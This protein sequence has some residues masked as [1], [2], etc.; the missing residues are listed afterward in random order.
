MQ[1]LHWFKDEL[2]T[3]RRLKFL[4]EH[5][6]TGHNCIGIWSILEF[7]LSAQLRPNYGM[8]NGKFLFEFQTRL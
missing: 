1:M 5:A 7:D 2:Y 4:C 6:V 3:E 8:F